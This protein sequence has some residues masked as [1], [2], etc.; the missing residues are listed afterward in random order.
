MSIYFHVN[1]SDGLVAGS[2]IVADQDYVNCAFYPV[3][4]Y[5][6]RSDLE[7]LVNELFPDGLTRLGIPEHRDRRFRTIVTGHSGSS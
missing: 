1:R 7:S 4:G 2:V 6:E 5:F 3:Q